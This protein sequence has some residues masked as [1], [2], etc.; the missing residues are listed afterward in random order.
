MTKKNSKLYFFIEKIFSRFGLGMRAKLITLFIL[1]KVLPLILLAIVAWRQSWILGQEL[2]KRALDL[3]NTAYNA[4]INAGNIAARDAEEALDERARQDI[5]RMTTDTALRVAS[6]LYERDDDILFAAGLPRNERSYRDFVKGRLGRVLV[7]GAWKLSGDGSGWVPAVEGPGGGEVASSNKENDIRFHYRPPDGFVYEKR[8]LFAEMTFIDLDGR[9][10]LKVVT[11]DYLS[12]E[13]KDVSRRENTFVKAEDYFQELKKLAPGEIYVSDVIGAYVGSRIIGVFNPENA[14]KAGIAYEPENSAYAGRENPV[15]RRFRGIV[16]WG[17][18]VT[19]GGRIVGFVTLALNHDHIMEFVD[20][21]TPMTGRYIELPDAAEGNYAF[22]WDYKGRSVAHPRHFSIVGYDPESGDPQIPWLEDRIYDEWRASGKSFAEFIAGVPTFQDQSVQRKPAAELTRAGLVGL[23]CRYLNFAPQCTGWFDLT[24]NGGSGSFNILWSGLRK[25]TTAAAIPYYTGRYA[26]SPRG[27]GFVAIGAG[28]DDFHRP[29]TESKKVIDQLIDQTDKSL[30]AM[31]ADAQEAIEKNLLNTAAS[32]GLSTAA[33][34]VLVIL[35][36]IWLASFFAGSI[37]GLI[38]GISRFRSGYREFRFNA[39]IKDEMGTLADAFDDMAD[40]I[41]Q[42]AQG[43]LFITDLEMR[44][45]YMNE[46]S[47]Q[48]LNQTLEG[49]RGKY[50]WEFSLFERDSPADPIAAL[51]NGRKPVNFFSAR[52]HTYYLGRANYF[53]NK[54]GGNIGYIVSLSNVTDLELARQRSEKQHA[55]L[56]HLFNAFPDVIAYRD[57]NGLYQ[58]VNI[59]FRDMAGLP[60]GSIIGRGPEEVLPPALAGRQREIEDLALRERKAQLVEE[61][62]TFA[63]GHVETVD[64]VYTPLFDKS[65]RVMGM[66]SVSRDVTAHVEVERA[67]RRT[68]EKLEQAV[69]EANSANQSKSAFL[70]RMSH[71]IRTPMNAILGLVG[72]AQRKLSEGEPDAESI[73]RH[74]SQVEQSSRHLLGLIS[75]I[76]DISKIEAGKIELGREPF[77]LSNMLDDVDTIIRPRCN[78]GSITFV[79]DSGLSRVDCVIG[80]PL[81][82]RQVLINLLGNAVKFTPPGGS[83]TLSVGEEEVTP[84][85]C[86]LRFQVRDTGIGMDLSKFTNLF[87]PFEQAD[88]QISQRYGGTGLGLSISQSIVNMMGGNISV[89]SKPGEGSSFSFEIRLSRGEEENPRLELSA[90][91]YSAMLKGRRILLVDDNDINRLIILEMLA[92]YDLT[93]DEAEDGREALEAFVR[94]A[95]GAYDLILMDIQMPNMDG[96]E[97]ARGIRLS[98]RPD[99]AGVPIIAMTANAFKEDVDKALESG[100]NAHIPKPVEFPLMLETIARVLRAGEK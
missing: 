65:G 82:L 30:A 91:D 5:E 81:R 45:I 16:R 64:S 22:I 27:F 57:E 29:A 19:D 36:A 48:R 73:S 77:A 98:A 87:N 6:F 55:L 75:D 14:A 60:D 46:H 13:L 1:I 53:K 18:P 97:A 11:A 12:K 47:L 50:Y 99:A 28:L 32:L 3:H 2:S 100:M 31:S 72:I 78:D 35:V 42:T 33:M 89:R 80:D 69:S 70:A 52:D 23:D 20:R 8:P 84:E 90:E 43:G 58:V 96:Y 38:D 51:L 76:L 44:Y 79:I 4:L 39:P 61:T 56:E 26:H 21:I 41:V 86:L 9:E 40:N 62:I 59:R 10:R 93:L 15:G 92:E 25:L 34:A 71:E 95:P 88:S 67:L 37:R 7:P 85:T 49:I 24:Q 83:V 68:Q 66:L 17:T 54:E 63:D 74:L 94:S